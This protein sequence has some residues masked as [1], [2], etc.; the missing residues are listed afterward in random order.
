MPTSN[1][2][3]E[4]LTAELKRLRKPASAIDEARLQRSSVV[5]E[6]P[7]LSLTIESRRADCFLVLLPATIDQAVDAGGAVILRSMMLYANRPAD[8]N[9]RYID[10]AKKLGISEAAVRGREDRLLFRLASFL[11]SPAYLQLVEAHLKGAEPA[12][13]LRATGAEDRSFDQT[14]YAYTFIE[15]TMTVAADERGTARYAVKLGVR[16]LVNNLR[17]FAL[18]S[19]WPGLPAVPDVKVTRMAGSTVDQCNDAV[20]AVR[21]ER[22]ESTQQ[23]LLLYFIYFGRAVGVDD[24]I[25]VEYESEFG[26]G[27]AATIPPL[28]AY[29]PVYAS[30]SHVT[31]TAKVPGRDAMCHY[32]R[33]FNLGTQSVKQPRPAACLADGEFRMHEDRPVEGVTLELNWEWI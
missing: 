19:I 21:T 15:R 33:R 10:A 32:Y 12:A 13:E 27:A 2:A 6:L 11:L 14:G 18:E 24:V 1:P 20:L 25:Q 28:L 26:E 5:R 8:L 4:D 17:V 30:M 16:A 7:A 9:T 22:Q 29:T 23:D 3:A 31:L